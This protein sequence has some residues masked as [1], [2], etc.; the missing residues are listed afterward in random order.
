MSVHGRSDCSGYGTRPIG[1]PLLVEDTTP[2]VV[3]RDGTVPLQR[4]K[5]KYL[6]M[7]FWLL[8]ES[9]HRKKSYQTHGHNS[10]R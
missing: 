1:G 2:G 6:L 10:F 9:G 3:I 4:H 7:R 8:I 5:H